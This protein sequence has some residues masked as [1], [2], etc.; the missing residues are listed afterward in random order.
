[1]T[2]EKKIRV[3]VADDHPMFREGMVLILN[4]QPDITVVGEYENG[5]DAVRGVRDLSP[6]VAILDLKMPDMSGAAAASAILEERPQCGI[7]ILTTYGGGDDIQRAMR[8]GA[9]GYVLKESRKPEVLH[10]IREVAQGRLYISGAVGISFAHVASMPALT[11][12]ERE[13][14]RFVSEGKTNRDVASELGITE[15]TV[16]SH[17]NGILQKMNV[18]SR[19]EAAFMALKHG[20]LRN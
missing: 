20:L 13:I 17:V 12:R 14:L 6:D 5:R 4:D 2:G 18:G 11:R 16:K 7:L 15:G 1:M 19:T 10:A 8:S 3:I 9:R